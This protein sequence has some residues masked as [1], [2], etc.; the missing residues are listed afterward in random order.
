MTKIKS[1]WSPI[2]LN[3]V[4]SEI[5]LPTIRRALEH[6]IELTLKPR[7]CDNVGC[8]TWNT[9]LVEDMLKAI[10]EYREKVREGLKRDIYC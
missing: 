5:Y 8:A 2:W 1:E 10:D 7:G 9:V 3:M 6:Y 4:T